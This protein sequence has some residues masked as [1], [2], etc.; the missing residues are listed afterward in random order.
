MRIFLNYFLLV[1]AVLPLT[2]MNF[3]VS[4]KFLIFINVIS[5]FAFFGT[6]QKVD[7][8]IFVIIGIFL[9]INIL[10]ILFLGYLDGYTLFGFILRLTA[11]YLIIKVIG[12]DFLDIFPKFALVMAL[13]SIPFYIIQLINYNLLLNTFSYYKFLTIDI[14][15]L[16]GKFSFFF[17]TIDINAI[18]R[19]CGFLWEPGGFGY[20]IGMAIMLLLIKTK[21]KF[22]L[23]V[24][25]LIGVGL[26]T[27]STTFY[28]FIII[29]IIFT[30]IYNVR[31]HSGIIFLLPFF[32]FL[33]FYIMS[34]DFMMQKINKHFDDAA[35]ITS[36]TRLGENQDKLGR[37]GNFKIEMGDFINYPLG[38]GIN[39]NG[40]TKTSFGEFASGPCGLSHH[41]AR[42]GIL[43]LVFL[44]IMLS[45]LNFY[46]N[47]NYNRNII[48][49]PTIVIILFLF[50]NP[51]DRDSLLIAFL[52]LPYT[53]SIL[54]K[55]RN[56]KIKKDSNFFNIIN[57]NNY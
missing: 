8:F 18:E 49:Y 2:G 5:L 30:V 26:T 41:I 33:I 53:S 6:K 45:K 23:H 34:Q 17:Y 51:I 44:L 19:N 24:L 4:D 12:K 39:E 7:G 55:S 46:L 48:Y 31:S 1:L 25:L 47:K 29:T 35:A 36:T 28:I 43:G 37:Y 40:K 15:L 13:A 16:A 56:N 32:A 27:L 38:Y 21:F 20:F 10:S 57:Y 14:R 42:W 52:Y 54:I 3:T 9:L 50:S 22:N 11:P